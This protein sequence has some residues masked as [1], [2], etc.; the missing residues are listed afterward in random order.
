M[1]L[2]KG[3]ASMQPQGRVDYDV[4]I[5]GAGIS[6]ITFAYRLQERN[7]KL[8]Y[9]ILE[10]RDELG[11]TWSFFKYP[12]L[13]SDSDMHTFGFPWA[14]WT[15]P[16]PLA[17]G[18]AIAEYM[19][20][21]VVDKG[22]DQRIKVRHKVE[23][24][25]WS[26]KRTCWTIDAIVNDTDYV[27]LSSR[28]VLLATGYFDYEQ[29]LRAHVPGIE[30]FRG[31]VVHPQFWPEDLSV[32]E[33]NVAII[34]SGA[35]AIT[36]L[37]ALAREAKHTT[38]VQRSP[39]YILSIPVEDQFERTMRAHLPVALASRLIRL[40]WIMFPI[41]F[42]K[43]C[44]WFPNAARRFM[45]KTTMAELGTGES[46]DPHFNPRYNP[47]EQRM[48][49][50][51]DGDFYQ[52][53][54]DGRGS[55]KT[56]SI[57][58]VT[59]TSIKLNSGEELRPDIIVTATG[60]QLRLGGG[61]KMLVDGT[62]VHIPDKHVWRGLM[63]EDIPNLTFSFGYLDAAWTLGVDISAQMT[64][65]LLKQMEIDNVAAIVPEMNGKDK[66]KVSEIR[67]MPLKSTYVEKGLSALPKLADRSQW[68][69]RSTYLW[70]VLAL[71]FAD[72]RTDLRWIK[73]CN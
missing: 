5:V 38:I 18:S 30:Q 66:C 65:R 69:Q 27:T 73:V 58:E 57:D 26:S 36:L 4:V 67:F 50:C 48:C 72:I 17:D 22:I 16:K 61:I 44:L 40:K 3:R 34:G 59:Q 31:N 47:F 35:T 52:C 45:R 8:S 12:G 15:G 29:P 55:I 28:F 46:L 14:A 39:S 68:R 43:L 51:P 54:R 53:L 23:Q 49:M 6:G 25:S 41:M 70:E 42:R 56:G 10:R 71:R 63:L 19:R 24:L 60:L 2:Q 11:G 37:P 62:L 7:P 33:K 9:C 13:R 64:C 21:A 20:Q 32:K 1:L